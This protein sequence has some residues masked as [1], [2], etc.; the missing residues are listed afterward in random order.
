MEIK[1]GIKFTVIL[2]SG[3]HQQALGN[4]SILSN[5]ELLLSVLTKKKIASN[6]ILE[7]ERIIIE[8]SSKQNSENSIAASDIEKKEIEH[9]VKR[10]KNEQSWVL[11]EKT[12]YSYP[13]IFNPALISDVISLNFDTVAEELFK[14]KCK[15]NSKGKFQ[16][17]SSFDSP[18]PH[19]NK[20]DRFITVNTSF[21]EVKNSSGESIR[22]WYPHGS[23]HKPQHIVLGVSKYASLISKTQEIRAKYKAKEIEHLKNEPIDFDTIDLTWFSQII[24]Q[25]VL[26]LGASMSEMEWALWTAFVYRK[27]NFAQPNMKKHETPVFIMLDKNQP[28]PSHQKEWFQP[29]FENMDFKEQW[30]KLESIINNK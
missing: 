18:T 20:S 2:G 10:I 27:R 22:F 8:Q 24:N 30:E 28:L 5:W 19:G 15:V 4:N 1:S 16:N 3:Y 12:R 6:Y 29:L 23:I 9:L 17:K 21:R 13:D 7:F 25:P 11:E 26:I 14:Q